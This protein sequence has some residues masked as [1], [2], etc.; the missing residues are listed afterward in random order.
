MRIC[1]VVKIDQL[2]FDLEPQEA[3]RRQAGPSA[4]SFGL[5]PGI[6]MVKASPYIQCEKV[7]FRAKRSN[8]Q[9]EQD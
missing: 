2:C 7:K 5:L 3:I 6:D 9:C 8:N 1:K 4:P